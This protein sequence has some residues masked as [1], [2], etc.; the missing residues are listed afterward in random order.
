MKSAARFSLEKTFSLP[1][2][3][4]ACCLACSALVS[5]LKE[6]PIVPAGQVY[7]AR[8]A[9]VRAHL[10]GVDSI[11]V[12][13]VD[14]E[15]SA[16]V[17][18]LWTGSLDTLSR[19]PVHVAAES[20]HFFFR[21]MGYRRGMG[22]C[23]IETLWEKES[24]VT[25]DA[26]V[27]KPPT[28][29]FVDSI[30]EFRDQSLL[31]PLRIRNPGHYSGKLE[32]TTRQP[33]LFPQPDTLR[34]DSAVAE[35]GTY[36]HIM[37]HI[38]EPGDYV[39][40]IYLRDSTRILDSAVAK[41]FIPTISILGADTLDFGNID[42]VKAI[43]I[44]L[45]FTGNRDWLPDPEASWIRIDRGWSSD[46]LPG[47]TASL[48]IAVDRAKLTSGRHV[49]VIRAIGQAS[50]PMDSL[51]IVASK[52]DW[53]TALE[54]LVL[55]W[56]MDTVPAAEIELVGADSLTRGRPVLKT[57]SDAQG[58]F[59]FENL[60]PGNYNLITSAAN[61]AGSVKTIMVQDFSDLIRVGVSRQAKFE[62]VD[63]GW[64]H[65]LIGRPTL[66]KG[67]IVVPSRSR[68]GEG[69][70][71]VFPI[72]SPEQ[73]RLFPQGNLLDPVTGLSMEAAEIT[74]DTSTLFISYPA[75]SAIVAIRDWR[76]APKPQRIKLSFPV[77]GIKIDG[78]NLAAVGRQ[79]EKSL[80]LAE[81]RIS[82]LALIRV[83]S[84]DA[85]YEF[86]LPDGSDREGVLKHGPRIESDSVNYYILDGTA[87][88][89]NGP[90]RILVKR[91]GSS[92][93]DRGR[94]WPD[95]G[96]EKVTAMAF[97]HGSTNIVPTGCDFLFGDAKGVSG[98]MAGISASTVFYVPTP[99][100]GDM[101][102]L[103]QLDIFSGFQNLAF[104]V[105]PE[106]DEVVVLNFM[107]NR[108]IGR[109]SLPGPGTR[110]FMEVPGYLAVVVGSEIYLANLFR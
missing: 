104:M 97:Y 72:G 85:G 18:R 99:P 83:Y 53:H 82:S 107:A 7:D 78:P 67:D 51:F 46:D 43:P 63:A 6:G 70:V 100:V 87:G 27:S 44:M 14:A 25:L 39:G 34:L 26:C 75:D 89:P 73:K 81:Y 103:F 86:G 49:A 20:E 59:R 8:E 5:C 30:L 32:L 42:S 58:R 60:R 40:Q 37:R 41:A 47:K 74:G 77:F 96:P 90:G 88:L 31:H 102:G 22:L 54:G 62:A 93:L 11:L 4:A 2:W 61:R 28:V 10:D 71:L 68:A 79:S 91:K 36:L 9:I 45:P 84:L 106:A 12:L 33:W 56:L 13:L 29:E 105:S 55:D 24:R 38:M 15:D 3:L 21:I 94:V 19:M 92:G 98:G 80:V 110:I 16:R 52:D 69:Q 109:L 50:R 66:I 95:V 57:V 35:V 23:Y 48:T 1:A 76:T 108:P 17:I 64:S 65:R 101:A